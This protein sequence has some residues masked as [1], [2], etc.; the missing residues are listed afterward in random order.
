MPPDRKF[1]GFDAYRKAIDCLK[2]GDVILLTTHAAFRPT[3]LE[4]AVEKGVNVFMEKTFAPDPGGVKQV[5]RAGQAA[6]A[7]NLKVAAGLMC[8]HSVAR[9]AM[10]QKIHDG[11][12]GPIELI[13]AYRTGPAIAMDPWKADGSELLWQIRRPYFFHWL[14]SGLFIEMT[15]H[16]I[17]EMLLDQGRLA[18]LGARH[19]RADGR[20]HR[21]Q[22]EPRH[23]LGRIHV[24]RWHPG[25]GRRPL[26]EPCH[27][28]FAT[29][30]QGT[31]SVGQFSGNIHAATVQIF[32]DQKM[33]RSNIAWKPD[34]EPC[35][36]W[37]AE[38]NDLI[39]AIRTDQPYNETRRACMSNTGGAHG[40]RGRPHRLDRHLGRDD[41]V[42]FPVLRQRRRTD[43]GQPLAAPRRR[44][45]ALCGPD[46]RRMDRGV[47]EDD[48]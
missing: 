36:P 29:Y 1:L 15:I 30:V 47:T 5:L 40:P 19:G 4:Y 13:R 39:R 46:S 28:D 2:P 14:S 6:E 27:N 33:T 3:H 10:L 45:G 8:R 7:K 43:Q 32:K 25:D 24:P 20:Q 12:M 31:R 18:G 42:E 9:Q 44:E 23:L 48:R 34:P 21:L 37:Q 11:A 26:R 41:V 16:Q 17:D 22:P 35:D 38:W